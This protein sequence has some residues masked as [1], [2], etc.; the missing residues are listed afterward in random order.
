MTGQHMIRGQVTLEPLG[1]NKIPIYNVENAC[2]SSSYAFNLAW[3]AVAAG[4]HDCVLVVGFEKLYSPDKSR[5]FKA[6]ETALDVEDSEVY[7]NRI[8]DHLGLEE[9]IFP[10]GGQNRSRLLDIYA[11]HTKRYMNQFGLTQNHLATLSVKAHKNGA[12]NPN[13][14]YRNM[15]S[16]DEVLR[17]GD[18]TYPFTRMMCA[19]ISDGAAAAIL[20]SSRVAARY[21]TSPVYV[22]A[23]VV[24]SGMVTADMNDTIVKRTARRLYESS[25]IGPEDVHVVEVHD[26]TSSA[27]IIDLIELGLCS[28][29]DAPKKIEEG[30]FDLDGRLPTNPSGGL[31]TKG[32]PVAA[33]GLG[34]IYEVVKQL[35][36]QAGKRQVKNPKIGM[37]QNGGGILG[38]DAAAM[39]LH[40]FKK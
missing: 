35:K 11:F 7:F 13:A 2:A 27:E 21:T 39:A 19:P 24:G 29:E 9:K 17:S 18:V 36:N 38:V 25:G 8:E 1:I 33:T 34:Q 10:S 23:S 6:L 26:T 3:T 28:G 16:L 31:T 12:L 20:C 32:H 4:V 40:L 30:Y 22:A 37:T 5:S 14:Q 15:V